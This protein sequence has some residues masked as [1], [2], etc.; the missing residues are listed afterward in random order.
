MRIAAS[1]IKPI[2]YWV[3]FGGMT[4]FA[5]YKRRPCWFHRFMTRLLLGWKWEDANEPN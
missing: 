5:H 2:G 4:K 1:N 3:M